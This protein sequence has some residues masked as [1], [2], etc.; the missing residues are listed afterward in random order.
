MKVVRPSTL[1]L[2]VSSIISFRQRIFLI[3]LHPGI[4][5][6][7]LTFQLIMDNLNTIVADLT[8]FIDRINRIAL[9]FAKTKRSLEALASNL[10]ARPALTEDS[11]ECWRGIS[12]QFSLLIY[13]VERIRW[14]HCDH[15]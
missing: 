7:H 6:N 9:W 10:G 15:C 3:T 13:K 14:H 1:H 12:D 4:D 8:P 11:A 2:G 5:L